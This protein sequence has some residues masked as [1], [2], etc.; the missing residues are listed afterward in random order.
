MRMPPFLQHGGPWQRRLRGGVF[1]LAV[2]VV[3]LLPVV[4][5]FG[6][7]ADI[8]P[9]A[10][11]GGESGVS[12][13]PRV[14]ERVDE[15]AFSAAPVSTPED[16][17]PALSASDAAT[18]DASG[19]SD[20]EGAAAAR[21]GRPVSADTIGP[22]P[23]VLPDKDDL[24]SAEAS[25]SPA[26][27]VAVPKIKLFGTVEFKR[28]LS[29]LPAWLDLLKRN[30]AD[31]IFIPEKHFNKK[32]TWAQ[33][34]EK[35]KGKNPMNLLRYVNSFWNTWPY[36]EDIENWG[37]ADYWE[38]PAE[39]LKKSGDCEDYSI[40][41]YFTLKELGIPPETMRIVVVRDTIRNMA[42]AVLV[43]YMNNDAYVLDSLS[44]VVLS[45][46]RFGHYS[47]QYSVNEFGRWA[48]LKGRKL[49]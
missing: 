48:H 47:P 16:A 24:P 12:E 41:K 23:A 7:A 2:A 27:A 15:S 17:A 4:G 21:V 29:S 18:P 40:I 39:F 32:M 38:I 14:L 31:P 35:A 19:P 33:F 26:A 25:A 36:R 22:S 6:F 49:K 1:A 43:V 8:T 46:T 45:H 37:Q 42:H 9:G 13:R 34:K 11:P 5:C 28:P 3:C 30:Q 10:V 44:N 20:P